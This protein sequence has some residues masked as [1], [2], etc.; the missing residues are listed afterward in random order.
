MA[1]LVD[2]K[3]VP[4]DDPAAAQ[5]A[6]DRSDAHV[7]IVRPDER[8]VDPVQHKLESQDLQCRRAITFIQT[9]ILRR[10]RRGIPH[11]VLQRI[12]GGRGITGAG[13]QRQQRC[14]GTQARFETVPRFLHVLRHHLKIPPAMLPDEMLNQIYRIL[15][16][17][18]AQDRYVR[19]TPPRLRSISSRSWRNRRRCKP[20]RSQQKHF[21]QAGFN[22]RRLGAKNLE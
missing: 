14:A 16:V 6:S 12:V 13:S 22:S 21:K 8:M 19:T 20:R 15:T 7:I 11:R 17:N 10:S 18:G 1:E 9:I 3:R 5:V 2:L 4:V